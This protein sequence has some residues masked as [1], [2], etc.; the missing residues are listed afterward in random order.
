MP[1]EYDLHWGGLYRVQI[2]GPSH[3]VHGVHQTVVQRVHQ[4]V[5][6]SVHHTAEGYTQMLS[7]QSGRDGCDLSNSVLCQQARW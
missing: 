5:A 4:T 6:H 2:P 7:S 3:V 1:S